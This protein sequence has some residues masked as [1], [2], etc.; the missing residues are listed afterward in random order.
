MSTSIFPIDQFGRMGKIH[1]VFNHSFNLQLGQRLINVSGYESPKLS[2]FGISIEPVMFQELVPYLQQD[3][4]VK[5]M[6]DSLTIYSTQGVK[7]I[8]WQTVEEVS[9]QVS[10]FNLTLEQQLRLKELLEQEQLESAIGLP[11]TD[12]ITYIE[13]LKN[14]ELSLE[15]WQ[16]CL[17]Y[18]IGRGKGLTPSGDD[19]LVA[20]LVMLKIIQ[21]E[22]NKQLVQAVAFEQLSTTAI[23]KEYIY[24]ALQ[25]YCH[26]LV[27]QLFSALQTNQ[28]TYCLQKQI[29]KIREIGHSS[30][31]DLSFGLLLALQA[32]LS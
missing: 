20:Y 16:A 11:V 6:A 21:P 23:S 30:G 32:Q 22:Q 29:K 25:G 28:E 9:L 12:A 3:N 18:F 2:S 24:Y 5:V 17:A 10:S 13:L 4:V 26:S 8:S 15:D 1:S 27:Y 7:K 31:T 19:I 14:K